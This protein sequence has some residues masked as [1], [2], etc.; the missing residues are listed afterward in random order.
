MS[1]DFEITLKGNTLTLPDQMIKETNLREG[2]VIEISLVSK[3]RFLLV[4]ADAH[5]HQFNNQSQVTRQGVEAYLTAHGYHPSS[6]STDVWEAPV[7]R[8]TKVG[9]AL[10]KIYTVSVNVPELINDPDKFAAFVRRHP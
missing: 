6:T 7:K 2:D 8:T 3:N 9:K 10:G 1:F 4:R 5:R